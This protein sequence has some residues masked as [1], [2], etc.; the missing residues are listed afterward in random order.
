ML[1]RS[2][3]VHRTVLRLVNNFGVILGILQL[4][5]VVGGFLCVLCT[6]LDI[7]RPIARYPL[8]KM[9]KLKDSL[10][11]VDNARRRTRTDVRV[12]LHWIL[13]SIERLSFQGYI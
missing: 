13:V 10:M 8:C 2:G 12:N 7:T 9:A 1:F 5:L 11:N 6:P 3:V 4:Y